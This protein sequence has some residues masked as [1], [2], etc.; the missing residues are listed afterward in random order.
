MKLELEEN[1]RGCNF[2]ISPPLLILERRITLAK[3]SYPIYFSRY[4]LLFS[5]ICSH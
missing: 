2:K 3:K 5:L 1:L 4:V